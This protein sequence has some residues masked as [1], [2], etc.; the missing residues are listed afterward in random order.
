MDFNS[1]LKKMEDEKA[2]NSRF[3]K[4]SSWKEGEVKKFKRVVGAESTVG[5]KGANVISF[6]FI[7]E[8]G[9]EK[10]FS[11]PA[12]SNTTIKFMQS[13]KDA[14]EFGEGIQITKTGSGLETK[15]VVEPWNKEEINVDEISM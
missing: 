3:I 2:E 4:R 8:K 5:Y 1:L 9:R 12:A 15:Y 13:I 11:R 7:D 14:Q 6:T 10:I